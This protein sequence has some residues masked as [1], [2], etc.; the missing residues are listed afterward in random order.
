MAS[1]AVAGV[2]AS[3]LRLDMETHASPR[4]TRDPSALEKNVDAVWEEQIST[5]IEFTSA[6]TPLD[7]FKKARRRLDDAIAAR[8]NLRD[9]RPWKNPP[10]NANKSSLDG[11]RETVLKLPSQRDK[12]LFHRFRI[13]NGEHLDAVG[14]VKRAG[15]DPEQFVPIVNVA[16]ASWLRIAQNNLPEDL[17]KVRKYCTELKLTRVER[18]DLPCARSF[19]FDASILIASRWKSIFE[20]LNLGDERQAE[21]WG[22]SNVKPLLDRLSEPVPYV[23]CLVADGDSV[24]QAIDKL[25]SKGDLQQFSRALASF[26]GEAR[27]I[28]EQLHYGSLVY[29]GGDD[30]LAFV[31]LPEALSCAAALRH[32]FECRV[33]EHCRDILRDTRPSLSVGVGIGH[34][35]ES[36]GDLLELGREAERLAKGSEF[37]ADRRD[38]NAL[39]VIV[40]KRSGGRRAWR[41]RWDD[42]NGDLVARLDSDITF[43]KDEFS[44][45]KIYEIESILRRLPAPS[46]A[47]EDEWK[48]VL[49]LEVQR[50]LTRVSAGDRNANG[51]TVLLD[52]NKTASY[53]ELCDQI[54]DWVDR[55]LIARTFDKA[56][57]RLRQRPKEESV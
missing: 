11:A 5:L 34:I 17:E 38:R 55:T 9:F 50:S 57:P 2:F 32:E 51:T 36:M 31:P 6:W 35:T 54:S 14:L 29:S 27:K 49:T 16:L 56:T 30:V 41:A 26:A 24:G 43:L 4:S 22:R 10:R 47:T 23:A 40:D 48:R 20:E 28:V 33:T 1:S 46:N 21:N 12:S 13:G 8:K 44:T 7:T 25:E 39:A 53:G 45:R 18:R 19:P 15:G 3:S 42:W 52:L 37:R